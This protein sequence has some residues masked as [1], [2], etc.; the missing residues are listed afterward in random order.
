MKLDDHFQLKKERNKHK[1]QA[2]THTK[3]F[4]KKY[5]IVLFGLIN[6]IIIK[7]MKIIIGLVTF[8]F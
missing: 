5:F 6:R 3:A 1:N 2:N 4:G 7:V 8:F